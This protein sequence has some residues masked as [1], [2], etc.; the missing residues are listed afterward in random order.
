MR[1]EEK[2]RSEFNDELNFSLTLSSLSLLNSL[3]FV[4]LTDLHVTTKANVRLHSHAISP[5]GNDDA[6]CR[7]G[8]RFNIK[9][10]MVVAGVFPVILFRSNFG[11]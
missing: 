9:F 8:A 6:S 3:F 2:E 10:A 7:R 4:L 11:S 1:E 5:C